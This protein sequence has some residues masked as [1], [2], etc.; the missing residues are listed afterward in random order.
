MTKDPAFLFYPG[1]YL[2]DTQCLSESAQVAYD[3]IMCEHMRSIPIAKER[4]NFF[5]KRLSDV[6][7]AELKSVLGIMDGGF[8]IEWL[9]TSINKRRAYSESR[10]QNGSQKHDLHMQ[11]TGHAQEDENE[12]EDEGKKVGEFDPKANFEVLWAQYPVKDGKKAAARSFMA[13][14]KSQADMAAIEQALGNY[15]KS[16][17]VLKGFTKNGSTWFANWK[18]WVTYVPPAPQEGKPPAEIVAVTCVAQKMT[19]LQIKTHM[20]Q[21][22]YTEH[23]IDEA[24]MRARGKVQ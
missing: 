19:D 7:K 24:I 9:Y 20:L 12:I 15:L 13:S 21:K 17:R 23:R 6:E 14:V 1:D 11:S 2:R 16:E 3:R 5:T 4:L 22:G 10:R 18:D 8:V